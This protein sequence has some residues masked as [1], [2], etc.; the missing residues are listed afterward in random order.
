M[1]TLFS[2]LVAFSLT[3][4]AGAQS[5]TMSCQP[6]FPT[7]LELST[8]ANATCPAEG[9]AAA[10]T[11]HA[12]QNQAKNNLCATGAPAEATFTTFKNLQAQL[13]A[14]NI[15]NWSP[16]SLPPDRSIFRDLTTTTNG[17]KL[18]EGSLVKLV[19]YVMKVK[20]GG[21]E[22]VNCGQSKTAFIDFHVVLVPTKT[23]TECAS[24][25]AEVIPHFRPT[26]WSAAAI[27][28]PDVPMRFT[29]QLFVDA[30]HR[31]CQNGVAKAGNPAR[32]GIV[33]IHPVYAIDVCKFASK[34]KCDVNDESVWTP[35]D[36]W[37][38]NEN[39]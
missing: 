24:V 34:T 37:E 20:K 27:N 1:R 4:P 17:D 30:S 6:P 36:Q 32:L 26:T 38:A 16:N 22:S 25:T 31:P 13:V 15:A 39:G 3:A 8:E 9:S 33:E 21:K 11:P 10:G 23:S 7:R 18:G 12:L 2:I 28:T 29:G 14:R 19:A 5:F 35:L